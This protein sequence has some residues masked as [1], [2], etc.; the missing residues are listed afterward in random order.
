MR[1]ADA[2]PAIRNAFLV[3]VLISSA[4]LAQDAAVGESGV[5]ALSIEQLC[6]QRSSPEVWAEIERRGVFTDS[7][8]HA[9]EKE[10][11]R[12]GINVAA[13]SCLLGPPE[14]VQYAGT[15]PTTSYPGV[16]EIY[17]YANGD[18]TTVV[19]VEHVP[20]HSIVVDWH[21]TE[22]R[23]TY[24][25]SGWDART[26]LICWSSG[27]RFPEDGAPS[28]RDNFTFGTSSGVGFPDGLRK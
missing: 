11:I 26:R 27:C 3:A 23:P 8:L 6:A 17:F 4:S 20:D 21:E 13:V 12:T 16:F 25:L 19:A 15:E 2:G 9:I 14:E 18:R 7:D 22:G 10:K 28:P 24:E 1:Q 5:H